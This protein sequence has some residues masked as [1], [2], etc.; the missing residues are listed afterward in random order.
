MQY[1]TKENL[2]V[3]KY[4]NIL[5]AEFY[6]EAENDLSLLM[7]YHERLKSGLANGDAKVFSDKSSDDVH[8]LVMKCFDYYPKAFF[9]DG[10]GQQG[11][12]SKIKEKITKINPETGNENLI[13]IE[14]VTVIG[15]CI[16]LLN[17]ITFTRILQG[18]IFDQGEDNKIY[19][20][21]LFLITDTYYKSQLNQPV[22]D[23]DALFR[24]MPAN[25][26]YETFIQ[27]NIRESKQGFHIRKV[28]DEKIVVSIWDRICGGYTFSLIKEGEG[29]YLLVP[30]VSCGRKKDLKRCDKWKGSEKNCVEKYSDCPERRIQVVHAILLCMQAYFIRKNKKSITKSKKK[31]TRMNNSETKPFSMDEM[32]SVFD[33]GANPIVQTKKFAGTGTSGVQ[34]RPHIRSGHERHLQNGSIV[35]VKGCVIHKEEY[36]GY[37]S[38]ERIK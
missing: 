14:M 6:D 37:R 12:L 18:V 19:Y 30:F 26:S 7:E 23:F 38:A 11:I 21:K 5:P 29:S 36:E 1:I 20:P 25:N 24:F 15:L 22:M 17:I 4:V 35:Q 32:I 33:Y 13:G 28:S 3:F 2:P 34:K 16:R 10:P 9:S 27:G 8:R 31:N